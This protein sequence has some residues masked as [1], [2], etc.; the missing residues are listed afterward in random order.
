[1]KEKFFC[2]RLTKAETIVL[3]RLVLREMRRDDTNPCYQE[4][5]HS[6]NEKFEIWLVENNINVKFVGA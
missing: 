3:R 5:L 2:K 6:I 1:M 4:T